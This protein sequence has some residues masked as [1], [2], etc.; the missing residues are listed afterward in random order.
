M[1]DGM[2]SVFARDVVRIFW[3][4]TVGQI[5]V[6]NLWERYQ[7]IPGRRGGG[8]EWSCWGASEDSFV[9]GIFLYTCGCLCVKFCNRKCRH[10][11]DI[12]TRTMWAL[13]GLLC[14]K[15]MTLSPLFLIERLYS[16]SS[17]T[18]TDF[19]GSVVSFRAT[20]TL[21]FFCLR[22]PL[23]MFRHTLTRRDAFLI[24]LG[25]SSM[26]IWSILFRE[27]PTD[28]SILINTQFN[29]HHVDTHNSENNL[30]GVLAAAVTTTATVTQTV[31]ESVVSIPTNTA[32]AEAD[33]QRDNRELPHT[34]IIAHAPG[35]T[36]FKNLYMSNGTLYIIT[37]RPKKFPEIRSMTSTGLPAENTPENIAARE[38][39]RD[40]MDFITPDDALERWGGDPDQGE[41]NRVWTVEGNT[42]RTHFD[43]NGANS[44]LMEDVIFASS[45]FSMILN[46]SCDIIITWW[47][48]FSS[49]CK[50]FGTARFRRQRLPHQNILPN[51]SLSQLHLLYTRRLPELTVRYSPILTPMDGEIIQGSTRISFAPHI[52]L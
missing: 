38:P 28:Q 18:C 21:V 48:N 29:N 13:S 11:E 42:V 49:A 26:H 39:T 32:A 19:L 4:L 15:W 14:Q 46:S 47:R 52:L 40:N 6:R 1:C 10:F 31:T 50:R 33:R 16:F 36:L 45:F 7:L 3:D 51:N 34:T 12:R 37:P 23:F 24:L 30:E 2:G 17:H 20:T 41:T 25:A 9:C 44:A 5:R 43:D 27:A 8:H 22:Y 35:W